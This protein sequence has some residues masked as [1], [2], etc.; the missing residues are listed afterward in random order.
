MFF[1]YTILICK[2]PC[3]K[4]REISF[5]RFFFLNFVLTAELIRRFGYEPFVKEL[6]KPLSSLIIAHFQL[7]DNKPDFSGFLI[8]PV[9]L[10]KRRMKWRGFSQAEEIGKGTFS[11][12]NRILDKKILLV[13]DV[14][15]TGA[16]MAE[17]ARIL[18]ESGAK[19]II[20][21]AIARG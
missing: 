12:K 13:D 4:K 20:G 14:Y 6:V 1:Y 16:T 9:P 10:G 7:M 3:G 2:E 19:E 18:R 5:L 21:I 8:I 15:T 11:V 17:C